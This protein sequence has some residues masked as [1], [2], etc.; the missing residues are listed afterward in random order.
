MKTDEQKNV[1][2]E[3]NKFMGYSLF[4][5]V[6]DPILRAYNRSC[7]IKNIKDTVGH[8]TAVN[9]INQFSKEDKLKISIIL[10]S[11]LE[12]GWEAVGKEIRLAT[13]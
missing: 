2:Q 1:V 4:K 8:N 6:T 9:Y 3:E 5:D 10:V 11:V 13:T 12:H 7:V